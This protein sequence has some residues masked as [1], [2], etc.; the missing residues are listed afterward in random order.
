MANEIHI[1]TSV[2]DRLLVET[3]A[4]RSGDDLSSLK[5][6]VMRDLDWL[7]NTHQVDL[8]WLFNLDNKMNP[9]D[10]R[11][12]LEEAKS[13]LE[14]VNRSLLTYGLPDFAQFSLNN[15]GDREGVRR[16]LEEAISRF[17]P[18]LDNVRVVLRQAEKGKE[19]EAEQK[20]LVTLSVEFVVMANLKVEPTPVPVVFDTVLDLRSGKYEVKSSH[21]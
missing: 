21:A 9:Q 12:A 10:L 8:N 17:E 2:L 14:A 5:Q 19:Q 18:R 16:A 15:N 3:P 20:A 11:R 13:R 1:T 7:L 6:S 4:V